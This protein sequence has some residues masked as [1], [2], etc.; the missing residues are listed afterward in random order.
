MKN[1][2]ILPFFPPSSGDVNPPKSLGLNHLF[3]ILICIFGKRISGKK[4]LVK[5]LYYFVP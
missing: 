2:K 4:M 1:W 5:I 3:L